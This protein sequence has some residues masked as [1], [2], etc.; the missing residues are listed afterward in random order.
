MFQS[1]RIKL[2]LWYLLIVLLITSFFSFLIYSGVKDEIE[3]T[4]RMMA[5]RIQRELLPFTNG[6]QPPILVQLN[7]DDAL[8][9]VQ[10]SMLAT[11]GVI[12]LLA[13]LASYFL[14][15]KTL[16]PIETM[17]ENQKQFISDASHE[18]RTPI[19]AMKTS[20]EVNV[21]DTKTSKSTKLLLSQ[22]LDKVTG[23]E[24]LSERLLT[25]A[26]AER[27]LDTLQVQ[28]VPISE[29]LEA[30]IEKCQDLAK[31][32]SI[33]LKISGENEL[34]KADPTRLQELFI[35]L[36][37]NAIKYSPEHSEIEISSRK[38][39]QSLIV[40]VIDQGIGIAKAE[41]PHI[42]ERFYR[43]DSARSRSSANGYGLG[44]AIAKYIADMHHASIKVES[45]PGRGSIFLITFPLVK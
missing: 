27:M 30:S 29:V 13:A 1:A 15:G 14:A 34:V 31:A 40:K 3:R 42:F 25:L 19:A 6:N 5:A 7:T 39:N 33:R 23:L 28:E 18:L 9:R 8:R 26:R 35:I 44:L 11:N 10:L 24:H 37:D 36:I 45:E 12:L 43:V 22:Y 16:K 21:R 2:T 32:K 20:L 4:H 38:T 17:V 41:I